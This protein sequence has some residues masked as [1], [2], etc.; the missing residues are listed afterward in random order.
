[1]RLRRNDVGESLLEPLDKVAIGLLGVLSAVEVISRDDR[2]DAAGTG[3]TS[4]APLP[5]YLLLNIMTGQVGSSFNPE[6]L[7]KRGEGN[8][9]FS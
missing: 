4:P 9:R 5:T 2:T 7:R 6:G 8:S 1:M 3:I